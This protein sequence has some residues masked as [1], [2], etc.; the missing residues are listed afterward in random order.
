VD[1]PSTA[2]LMGVPGPPGQPPRMLLVH[3]NRTLALHDL[4]TGKLL[5]SAPLPPADYGPGNPTVSGGLI[6][7][8][9]PGPWGAQIS[10]YDPV[11]RQRRWVR[12]AGGAYQAEPCGSLTCLAGPYGVRAVDPMTGEERWYRPGWQG[13]E[14]RGKLLLAYASPAGVS[15]PVGLIDARTGRVLVDLHGWRA[16]A[17]DTG[18]HVLVTR[19]VDAGARTMVAVAA[20]GVEQPRPLAD[21]PPGTGECQTAPDRLICRSMSGQ[22]NVWA[23]RQKG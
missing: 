7:L 13:V 1:V 6:V 12:P 22:L 16:L 23:Y 20:P 15:E 3:D 21:L 11:T 10:A 17:G 5:A 9:H 2:V 8:R 4:D 19:V 18:D 14:Q